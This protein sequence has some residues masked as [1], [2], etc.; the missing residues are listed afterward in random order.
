VI[1][2]SRLR[3]AILALASLVFVGIAVGSLLAPHEMADGL[4]YTLGNVDALSEFRAIYVGLWLS[5]AAVLLVAGR[6]V[7]Q[8]LLGDLAAGLILGQ[9]L[10]RLLSLV[11]DGPPTSRIWPMFALET[12]GG[13]ALLLVRPGSGPAATP[14]T[15]LARPD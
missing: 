3:Q 7:E 15:A 9:T 14:A 11:L 10:G 12:L 4:G 5:I 2:N 6:R 8:G 13:I 1:R